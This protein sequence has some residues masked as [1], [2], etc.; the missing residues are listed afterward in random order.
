M[1]GKAPPGPAMLLFVYGTLMRGEVAHDRLARAAFVDEHVTAPRFTLYALG[2]YPGAAAGGSTA[3]AGELYRVDAALLDEL[4]GYEGEEYDAVE[5][6]TSHGEAW[7]YV[8]RGAPGDVIVS[9]CWRKHTGTGRG[10]A[11]LS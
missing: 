2:W 4:A 11:P 1:N 10:H 5:I 6:P 3:I 8:Y 9:G 7:M